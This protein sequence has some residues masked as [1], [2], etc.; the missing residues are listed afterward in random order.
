VRILFYNHA[1][2]LGGA[3]RSLLA[4]MDRAR[5]AGHEILFCAPPGPLTDAVRHLQVLARP[6][7]EFEVGY[8]R[9]PWTMAKY[10]GRLLLP[11]HDLTQAAE[12]FRPELIHA[13]TPRSGLVAAQAVGL[14]RRR[15]ALVVH[16][17]D[18]LRHG[19]SD[20]LVSMV[21]GSRADAIV[22]I[23]HFVAESLQIERQK[24]RVL[25]N[26]I[27]LQQYAYDAAKGHDLRRLLGIAPE[28]P[29][30]AVAGQITPWK[31]QLEAMEALSQVRRRLPMA[32]LLIAG[33]VKF[34]GSHRRY[35]NP[36]YYRE[37]VARSTRADI[38][39]HVHMS[40]EVEASAIYSAADVLLVPSWAEPFGRVVIEAMSARCPVVATAAG[41]IPEIIEHE[42]EGLLGPP[43]D[44]VALAHASLRVLGDPALRQQL[45]SNGS[46]SVAGRFS[47]DGYMQQLTAIWIAAC[48]H[49][50]VPYPTDPPRYRRRAVEAMPASPER[51]SR[52]LSS[53]PEHTLG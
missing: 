19:R 4:I 38:A 18:S 20:W 17:R 39:G 45:V 1:P 42:V 16:V 28:V 3:E 50:A 15:P 13:N 52:D 10:L 32:H 24:V 12:Q 53:L 34:T 41:G 48:S 37:L 23:S 25:H 36:A 9:A 35:D 40:G 43:R 51:E 31:G 44:P 49:G 22:A 14:L 6:V 46:R 27:D 2:E 21:I 26:A 8:T 30:L 11:V 29:L 47:L 5:D 7:H 33:S